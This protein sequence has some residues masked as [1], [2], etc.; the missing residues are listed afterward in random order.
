[1]GNKHIIKKTS[2][3]YTFKN[4]YLGGP[5]FF[6]YPSVQI[7]ARAP[8]RGPS[9]PGSC[10]S[11][12]DGPC[13][14]ARCKHPWGR[15]TWQTWHLRWGWVKSSLKTIENWHGSPIWWGVD[16]FFL[17]LEMDGNGKCK[18]FR[19]GFQDC[20]TSQKPQMLMMSCDLILNVCLQ[21][22]KW[23]VLV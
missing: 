5:F 22:N 7:F 21:Q 13:P 16:D 23:P 2:W 18:K 11:C 19:V 12:R 6:Q 10:G 4:W 14:D 8:C 3:F 17:N 1:M 20:K 9:P 15:G